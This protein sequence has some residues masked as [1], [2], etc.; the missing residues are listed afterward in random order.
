MLYG[1]LGSKEL[2]QRTFK[3]LEQKV[4]LECD[5]AKIPLRN[6]QGIVVLNIP[7]YTG[8][9]NFWGNNSKDD[10][11]NS[12]LFVCFSIT[13]VSFSIKVF[14]SPSYDDKTLEVVA[15]SGIMEMA[16]SRVVNI[17]SNRIAQCR[18][19]KIQI[20]GTEGVPVQ[21]DGEAWVQPP[22]FIYLVHK[23]RA[24]MLTRNKV[25]EQTLKT[26]SEKQKNDP[27]ISFL[28]KEEITALQV[29]VDSSA[30]LIKRIKTASLRNAC[31]EQDLYGYCNQV[32]S[33]LDEISMSGKVLEVIIILL[34]CWWIIINFGLFLKKC[35]RQKVTDFLNS[36]RTFHVES[37]LFLSEKAIKNVIY[38]KKIMHET[39]SKINFNLLSASILK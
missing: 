14:T 26:W 4:L 16:L 24:Q 7:S 19:V 1:L 20:L 5:G 6:V 9:V 10:D 37:S 15:I 39:N 30:T 22:G 29:V 38:F 11:V 21:V 27:T 2:V 13:N 36:V 23:N 25:F 8:G 28:N 18:S 31:I 32:S 17:K 34:R 33:N 35:L 3:N 12:F